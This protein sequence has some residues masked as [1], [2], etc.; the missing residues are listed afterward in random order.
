MSSSI[1]F[2]PAELLGRAPF[3]IDAAIREHILYGYRGKVSKGV[4]DHKQS[5]AVV[6]ALHSGV[7]RNKSQTRALAICCCFGATSVNMIREATSTLAHCLAVLLRLV[8]PS[9]GKRRSHSTAFGT[10][11]R[12]RSHDLNVDGSIYK[13]TMS[14]RAISETL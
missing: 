5:A 10:L 4:L 2:S 12:I 11:E 14:V 8:S 9:S 6:W 3:K 7:S 1:A 13:M